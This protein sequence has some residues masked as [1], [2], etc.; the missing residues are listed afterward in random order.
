MMNKKVLVAFFSRAGENFFPGG[1][2]YIE[3]GNTHIAAEMIAEI[4]GAD[5]FEIKAKN[6]YS[7]VYKECV[8]Q[9]MQEHGANVRPELAETIDV[10]GYDVVFLGYPN[11]CGT[12][13]MPVWTFL[14]AQ[15]WDGK[16]ICPFC[17]NEGSG[18]ANSVKDIANLAPAA[19]QKEGLSI[20]GSQVQ[21]A[22]QSIEA[23]IE[24]LK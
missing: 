19:E 15:N 11:W 6:A 12:M 10:S 21:D 1:T 23:W 20:K 13:P 4:C 18:L 22:K 2:K 9:A 16:V 3:K 8:A 7:D 17:T 5:L 24:S 14:E